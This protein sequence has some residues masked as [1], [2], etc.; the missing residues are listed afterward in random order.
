M[1]GTIRLKPHPAKLATHAMTTEGA[2]GLLNP[3]LIRQ[4]KT[5]ILCSPGNH[6]PH[7]L[8]LNQPIPLHKQTGFRTLVGD[9][10]F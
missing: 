5:A 3:R 6:E 4:V 1:D 10:F 8:L 2:E 7:T 9:A